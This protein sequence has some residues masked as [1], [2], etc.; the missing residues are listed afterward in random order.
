LFHDDKKRCVEEHIM[1]SL[2]KIDCKW[3]IGFR[4]EDLKKKM[5]TIV[6]CV[7]VCP[8]TSLC[9]YSLMLHAQRRINKYQLFNLCN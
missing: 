2:A 5:I 8:P 6:Y 9:S 7:K 4:K 3:L 1:T